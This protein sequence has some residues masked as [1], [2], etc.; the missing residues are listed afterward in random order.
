MEAQRF[1][2]LEQGK[3]AQAEAADEA[4]QAAW[5]ADHYEAMAEAR[6]VEVNEALTAKVKGAAAK[7]EKPLDTT[8]AVAEID[9]EAEPDDHVKRELPKVETRAKSPTWAIPLTLFARALKGARDQ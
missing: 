5:E 3:R 1:A 4:E 6:P 2:V 7:Q 8:R 9:G